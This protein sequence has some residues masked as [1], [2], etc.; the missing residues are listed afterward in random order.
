[1]H[2][3]NQPEDDSPITG[4]DHVAILVR[5]IDAALPFY[6]DRLGFTVVADDRIES[7]QARLVMMELGNSR[8]QLST[9]IGEGFMA[10]YLRAHGEGVHHIAFATSDIAAT[11]VRLSPDEPVRVVRGGQQRLGGFLPQRAN[12]VLFELVEVDETAE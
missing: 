5:D 12:N 7:V 11:A 2:T 10:E 8:L 6:T 4:I 3:N 9:P 1:M